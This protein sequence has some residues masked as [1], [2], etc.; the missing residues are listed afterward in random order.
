MS[1][2]LP[3]GGGRAF[4]DKLVG[5]ED[6]VTK[7]EEGRWAKEKFFHP[8]KSEPA[9]A[10]TFASGSLR[11]VLKFD[12]AF[13]GISPREAAQMDPQQRFLM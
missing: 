13:F 5:G 1:Y 10:Y 3:G 2:R 7:V 9:S 4:W 8:R 11:D 12:A 6:L